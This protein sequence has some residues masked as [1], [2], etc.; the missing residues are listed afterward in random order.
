LVGVASGGTK[1]FPLRGERQM[2]YSLD[3]SGVNGELSTGTVFHIGIEP[4]S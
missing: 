2:V 1:L 4:K 3:F